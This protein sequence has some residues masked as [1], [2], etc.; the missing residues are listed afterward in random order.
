MD[1]QNL[2]DRVGKKRSPKEQSETM[3]SLDILCWSTVASFR[4]QG[5][6]PGPAADI[7]R[8]LGK[9]LLT[10][11]GHLSLSKAWRPHK[12]TWGVILECRAGESPTPGPAGQTEL[13]SLDHR[14]GI[15]SCLWLSEKPSPP[16]PPPPPLGAA[17]PFWQWRRIP[18]SS[19]G[20]GTAGRP[21]PQLRP[22]TVL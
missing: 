2:G 8:M 4:E 21:A 7:G 6:N 1:L 15:L 20:T 19:P 12:T 5:T 22:S 11:P 14:D 9:I 16:P 3:D 10:R 17:S 18:R 13:C